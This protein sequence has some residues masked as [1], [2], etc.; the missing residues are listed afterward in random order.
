M[1]RHVAAATGIG[2]EPDGGEGQLNDE[3]LAAV[4]ERH[5]PHLSSGHG[6]SW[7]RLGSPAEQI[8][9]WLDDEG[10][11]VVKVHTLLARRGVAVPAHLQSVS[12]PSCA[13]GRRCVAATASCSAALTCCLSGSAPVRSTTPTMPR[14]ASSCGSTC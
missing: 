5:R 2:V 7:R 3:V 9:A 11:S 13:G 6:E 10:P 4:I 8:R 1:R 12:A 14:C